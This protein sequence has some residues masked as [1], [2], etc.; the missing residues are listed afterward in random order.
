MATIS[1]TANELYNYATITYSETSESADR[2]VIERSV[3]SGDYEEIFDTTTL[4]GSYIDHELVHGL[5]NEYRLVT[6][7]NEDAVIGTTSPTTILPTL[8][9]W[10]LKDVD[11]YSDSEAVVLFVDGS[12]SLEISN[13]EAL[14]VFNPL[15]RK[16]A[17]VIRDNE[18]KGDRVP[19]T[20]QFLTHTEYDKFDVLRQRQKVL[21]LSGPRPQYNWYGVFAQDLNREIINDVDGYSVVD[22]EFIET[23]NL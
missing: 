15:G 8:K 2:V 1:A 18:V 23:G 19:L 6:Y 17:L 3:N 5:D 4:D 22:V 10:V 12:S 11:N 16:Y 14:A 9:E 21:K 7:D 13:E 20:L